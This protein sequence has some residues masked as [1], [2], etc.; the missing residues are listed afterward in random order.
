VS[1][2]GGEP[3]IGLDRLEII[4]VDD[5]STDG[6]GVLLDR[7]AERY[8]QIRRCWSAS[9]VGG[10]HSRRRIGSASSRLRRPFP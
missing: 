4:A 6:S 7:Y 10:W 2:L 1:R 5:G 9:A 3:I 8:P